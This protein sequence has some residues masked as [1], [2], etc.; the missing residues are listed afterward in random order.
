MPIRDLLRPLIPA[1]IRRAR[2][3]RLHQREERRLADLSVVEAFSQIYESGLW[4]GGPDE[5]FSGLG[6]RD[7]RIVLPY[8]ETIRAFADSF[9][10]KVDAVDLGCGDFSIGAQIRSAFDAY[11]AYDVVP[12]VIDQNKREYDG[13]NVEF[14]CIDIVKQPLPPGDVVMLRQV[15]QHLSNA[16]IAMV[17]PK[18]TNYR[19]VIITEHLP[20]SGDFSPNLDM[21]MGQGV[22][23]GRQRKGI[24]EDSGVVLTA[25]PFSLLV[26]SERVLCE[27]EDPFIPGSLIRTTLYEPAKG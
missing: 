1:A 24:A 4:G 3:N 22:R 18:L 7:P 19:Y 16:Q 15:L 23:V 5:Y 21:P 8:V 9:P 27:V 11:R 25:P 20:A 14:G 2:I 26:T 12:A 10:N 13:R 6:S 17:V